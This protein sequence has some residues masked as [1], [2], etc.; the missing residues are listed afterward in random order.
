MLAAIVLTKRKIMFK[1]FLHRKN[2][3]LKQQ[4]EIEFRMSHLLDIY[5]DNLREIKAIEKKINKPAI[6]WLYQL[7]R[8]I[9]KEGRIISDPF[10]LIA[11][12]ILTGQFFNY[13]YS[14]LGDQRLQ[15]CLDAINEYLNSK[16]PDTSYIFNR[17]TIQEKLGVTINTIKGYLKGIS[18]LSIIGW[19]H[20]EGNEIYYKRYQKGVNR[21]LIGVN[22]HDLINHFQGVQGVKISKNA[23]NTLNNLDLLVNNIENSEKD[24]VLEKIDTL[25]LTPSEKIDTLEDDSDSN[26]QIKRAD[27]K[28]F[29]KTDPIFLPC[30]SCGAKH[31][32]GWHFEDSTGKSPYCD[33]CVGCV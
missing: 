17:R 26:F 11:A 18:N 8:D 6:A 23:M 2:Y 13:T 5:F 28:R 7:Q 3:L 12:I 1:S 30:F 31:S 22:W 10:D 4:R 29:R 15:K 25:K 19:D 24:S 20:N 21:V 14:G 32:D 16:L 27:G 33:T 9:D